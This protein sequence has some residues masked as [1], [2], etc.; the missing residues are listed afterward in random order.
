[1]NI[2]TLWTR[3]HAVSVLTAAAAFV[4]GVSGGVAEDLV[5][6]KVGVFPIAAVAP[7][8]VGEEAG[9]FREE[10]LRVIPE[11]AAQGGAALQSAVLSGAYPF[12]FTNTPSVYLAR[13]GGLPVVMVAPAASAGASEEEAWDGLL[14]PAGSPIQSPADLEGKSVAVNTINNIGKVGLFSQLAQRGV[15]YSTVNLIEIPFPEMN[16]LLETGRL[17]AAW[18][19]TPFVTAGMEAGSTSLFSVFQGVGSSAT[20]TVYMSTEQYVAENPEIVASFQRALARAQAYARENPE[21][22]RQAIA[23][24]LDFPADIAA[25]MVLPEWKDERETD[26]V[27]RA[28]E[29]MVEYGMMTDVP[30]LEDVLADGF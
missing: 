13:A 8:Y 16:A 28:A 27:A 19:P 29:L 12:A 7:L 3:R 5:E 20:I 18:M 6:I 30:A 11:M 17:D 14:V 24:Y 4:G 22:T 1:M 26:S 25:T 10:G 23:D 15:D 2:N 9:I 21:I